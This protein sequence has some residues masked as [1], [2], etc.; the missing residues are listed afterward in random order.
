L[1][2]AFEALRIAEFQ[3]QGSNAEVRVQDLAQSA[4]IGSV[5]LPRTSSTWA[6]LWIGGLRIGCLNRR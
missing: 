2:P 4:N 5:S 1:T 6:S 3:Q